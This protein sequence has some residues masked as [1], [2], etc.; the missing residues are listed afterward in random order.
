[1]VTKAK[2]NFDPYL[3]NYNNPRDNNLQST[4]KASRKSKDKRIQ[5]S[6]L[7]HIFFNVKE[8]LDR[9]PFNCF[10]ALS[11]KSLISLCSHEK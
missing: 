8:K 5:E 10:E 3:W 7:S 11:T 9:R 2:E 1:M 6:S 4:R